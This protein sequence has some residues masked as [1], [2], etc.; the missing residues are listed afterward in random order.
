VKHAECT[1]LVDR[2]RC[3]VDGA[4]C[5]EV[6]GTDSWVVPY[7]LGEPHHHRAKHQGGYG[8]SDMEDGGDLR[9]FHDDIRPCRDLRASA[10][11]AP[12]LRGVPSDG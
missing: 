6:R 3:D 1:L 8:C 7:P 9:P 12:R 5:D 4:E 10:E 2:E 11:G